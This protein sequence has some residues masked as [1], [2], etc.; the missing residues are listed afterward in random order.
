MQRYW[1]RRYKCIAKFNNSGLESFVGVIRNFVFRRT[2]RGGGKVNT[3]AETNPSTPG[4]H[5]TD[6][7]LSEPDS[8]GEEEGKEEDNSAAVVNPGGAGESFPVEMVERSKGR[9]IAF[10]IQ[11]LMHRVAARNISLLTD[12]PEAYRQDLIMQHEIRRKRNQ[13]L[14]QSSGATITSAEVNAV[15]QMLSMENHDDSIHQPAGDVQGSIAYLPSY[16]SFLPLS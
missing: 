6:E 10:D 1:L 5:R 4:N 7:L 3:T 12:N 14:H 16:I 8:E 9:Q 2:R 11:R 13:V 15:Q